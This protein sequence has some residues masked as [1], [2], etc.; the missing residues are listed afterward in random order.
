M[1]IPGKE[2]AAEILHASARPEGYRS[3]R[4]N[5]EVAAQGPSLA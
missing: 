2:G 3:Q 1:I 5:A 4:R